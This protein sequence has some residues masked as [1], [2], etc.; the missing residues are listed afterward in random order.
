VSALS[1]RQLAAVERRI[2]E[3]LDQTITVPDLADVAGMSTWHFM[4]RFFAS[5][6]VS[7]HEYVTQKRLAR[8]RSLLSET[9][10]SITEIALEIGMSHSHF[11]RTFLQHC[12]MSPREYR[13]HC[14]ASN[15]G[16]L[17]SSA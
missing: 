10:T 7:P 5:H 6:G 11:S 4:R 17:T 9:P 14:E 13:K 1:R 3:T 2:D 12:G 8:A 15:G 16:A